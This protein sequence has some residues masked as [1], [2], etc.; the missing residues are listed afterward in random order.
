LNG[1]VSVGTDEIPEGS[2][3]VYFTNERVDDRVANLLTPGANV[4]IVYND[5]TNQIIISA[6]DT[7][8]EWS[9]IQNKP[10]TKI[11]VNLSGEISGSGSVTL[12]QLGN[13][14]LNIE[15]ITSNTYEPRNSNIHDCF[16]IFFNFIR[17]IY[18][19]ND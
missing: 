5:D 10:N 14:T 6:N 9:E 3:N 17:M 7:Q 18:V 12:S 19:F 1:V 4:S 13:G 8:V 15:N 2:A 16:N 11:D